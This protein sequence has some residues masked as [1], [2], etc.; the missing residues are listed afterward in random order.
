MENLLQIEIFNKKKHYI[1]KSQKF[2]DKNIVVNS[3]R[4][5][6]EFLLS[7]IDANILIQIVCTFNDCGIVINENMPA[8]ITITNT[9]ERRQKNIYAFTVNDMKMKIIEYVKTKWSDSDK[10]EDLIDVSQFK[11]LVLSKEFINKI[12]CLTQQYFFE[13]EVK[14]QSKISLQIE[15]KIGKDVLIE[16]GNSKIVSAPILNVSEW[17]GIKRGT[18]GQNDFLFA[19]DLN[20]FLSALN[21]DTNEYF[22]SVNVSKGVDSKE[23]DIIYVRKSIEDFWEQIQEVSLDN[24]KLLC[25]SK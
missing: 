13:K 2:I 19:R 18:V 12:I 3:I 23:Q 5:V 10:K 17:K 16:N 11:K 22:F 4:D 7:E 8:V 21:F 25:L 15:T 20:N 6:V 14:F 1:I 9:M 24:E